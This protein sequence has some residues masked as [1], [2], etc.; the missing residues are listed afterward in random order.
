MIGKLAAYTQ[1]ERLKCFT[2][3]VD[4][5]TSIPV[6]PLDVISFLVF[7]ASKK[8]KASFLLR[9][10]FLFFLSSVLVSITSPDTSVFRLKVTFEIA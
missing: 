4:R 3:R 1:A 7:S 9:K 5:I 6:E 2:S 8:K 10:Y